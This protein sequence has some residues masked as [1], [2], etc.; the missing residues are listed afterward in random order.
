MKRATRVVL[1]R[2]TLE[3]SARH[4]HLGERPFRR[5][6]RVPAR[7]PRRDP[8]LRAGGI[9][10]SASRGAGPPS[11]R[12][13]RGHRGRR[14]DDARGNGPPVGGGSRARGGPP[15]RLGQEPRRRLPQRQP[16]PGGVVGT[17]LGPP[18]FAPAGL[19]FLRAAPRGPFPAQLRRVDRLAAMPHLPRG[20]R[21]PPGR[22]EAGHVH[23]QCGPQRGRH[24][25]QPARGAGGHPSTLR[26]R[27]EYVLALATALGHGRLV[28]G[29]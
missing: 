4:L 8:L 26:Q 2:E 20:R 10:P 28:L 15:L 21:R 23:H 6:R 29:A 12:A 11:R 17:Q 27:S 18:C 25:E 3:I 7:L 24:G 22:A 16:G 5:H 1:A 9:G 13:R 14:R 19:D